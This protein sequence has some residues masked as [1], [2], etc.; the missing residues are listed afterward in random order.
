[1]DENKGMNTNSSQQFPVHRNPD[2]RPSPN[3]RPSVV[4]SPAETPIYD[5]RHG[6]YNQAMPM[7]KDDG[8]TPHGGTNTEPHPGIPTPSMPGPQE[9]HLEGHRLRTQSTDVSQTPSRQ[10]ASFLTSNDLNGGTAFGESN[11][12]PTND[13]DLPDDSTFLDDNESD[14]ESPVEDD[15]LFGAIDSERAALAQLKA[16]EGNPSAQHSNRR[17]GYTSMQQALTAEYA[18]VA[19]DVPDTVKRIKQLTSQENAELF[20]DLNDESGGPESIPT[21]VDAPD[22]EV[23]EEVDSDITPA[24][25]DAMLGLIP[26]GSTDGDFDPVLERLNDE[27]VL[28]YRD[29]D[30][31]EPE[32]SDVEKSA[33][34]RIE[35]RATEWIKAEESRSA[36]PPVNV[37]MGHDDEDGGSKYVIHADEN[38]FL[39]EDYPDDEFP[40]V[41]PSTLDDLLND[42]IDRGASDIHIAVDRP[43]KLR[44]NGSLYS[45]TKYH[46]MRQADMEALITTA[47][48]FISNEKR[49]YLNQKK[50]VDT[51]YTVESGKHAGERFRVHFMDEMNGTAIVMRHIRPQ[52]FTPEE[53][54][55]PEDCVKWGDLSQGLILVTGPTGSGKSASLS[56]I[57]HHIQLTRSKK[58]ITLEEP[59]ETTYPVIEGKAD[60]IQREIPENCPSFTAGIRDAMREDP[61][62][63][64]V[65]EIRDFDTIDAALQA[66]NTGHLT[67]ATIHANSAPAVITR[68]LD[69]A[70]ADSDKDKLRADLSDQ[71]KGIMSQRLLLKPG[72]DGRV[73]VRE[74]VKIGKRQVQQIKD[75]DIPAMY[76][77]LR[78]RGEDM[79]SQMIELLLEQR[80]VL[81]SVHE[82]CSDRERL[83]EKISMLPDEWKRRILIDADRSASDDGDSDPDDEWDMLAVED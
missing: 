65:G 80:T 76:D 70:G 12:N 49:T 32:L 54:G 45:F 6:H 13:D 22:T 26:G 27:L 36:I 43:I 71:L 10:S 30:D 34:R 56:S 48:S 18:L 42:A 41:T 7:P 25:A 28:P 51:S 21:P 37:M 66:S 40:E 14:D 61:D 60:V 15:D 67:F 3:H 69:L 1:M 68:I 46:I 24:E 62:V 19:D 74:I 83:D 20:K 77:D 16:K 33:L 29:P 50:S 8:A 31:P 44:I 5:P 53:I 75:G 38:Y 59:I 73:A 11:G 17:R 82:A 64:L 58:I 39:L 52:I 55:L 4:T 23:L 79:D 35:S 47:I 78:A 81:S 72:N 57:L 2:L 63:I 9:T